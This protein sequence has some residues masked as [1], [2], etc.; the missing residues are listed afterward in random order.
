M[1][2][3]SY[4]EKAKKFDDLYK[5]YNNLSK[6]CKFSKKLKL[7]LLNAPCNGFGDLIFVKKLAE[8]LRK[9]FK[10][11]VTI[12]TTEPEN[13]LKLGEKKHYLCKLASID[14]PKKRVRPCR[15]FTNLRMFSI[16]GTTQK[17]TDIYDLYFIAPLNIDYDPDLSDV[18]RLVPNATKF[19]TYF[20][21]EYNDSIR[22]KFDFHTGVS[23]NRSGILLTTPK[24]VS[25]LYIKKKLSTVKHGPFALVYVADI[26]GVKTCINS[27]LEMISK[28]YNKNKNF[29]IVVPSWVVHDFSTNT[30]SL[31]KK[32]WKNIVVI[33]QKIKDT[34]DGQSTINNTLH[35]RGDILPVKNDIMIGLIRESVQ[36]ILL[37]GDQSITDA[38][39]CCY[40]NKNIFYQIAPW[41]TEF[42]KELANTMPNKYL[43]S[44]K[45]SCG[46][47]SAIKYKSNYSDFVKKYNFFKNEHDRLESILCMIT[48]YK[49]PKSEMHNFINVVNSS[50]TLSQVKN[51]LHIVRKSKKTSRKKSRK[52]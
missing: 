14:K 13:L 7:L 49:N 9:T 21:S 3:I 4:I 34:F 26:D 11:S 35:I 1:T 37:T 31:L 17:N 25:A 30:I 46:T 2:L 52:K 39:S 6:S 18:K 50:K 42:G 32:Y 24:S 44:S 5:I 15:A 27:F 38:L 19:N 45:T 28:K 41:K 29:Q 48:N 36:D 51:K 16:D 43:K 12:A 22:K 40:K 10:I 47:L 33:T 20:F 23:K 8:Y